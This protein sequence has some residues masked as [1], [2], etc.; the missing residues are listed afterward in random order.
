MS[1]FD[2]AKLTTSGV[3]FIET[4]RARY[5]EIVK[6]AKTIAIVGVRVRPH[7][8]HL[9]EALAVTNAEVVYCSGKAA[10]QEFEDWASDD[11]RDKVSQALHTRFD[12]A[13]EK[14]CAS[15]GL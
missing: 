3:N 10:S 7:D 5:D 15:I 2:P 12:E 1:Y 6:F 13:F 11:R 9:W 8:K 14:P 4:Q